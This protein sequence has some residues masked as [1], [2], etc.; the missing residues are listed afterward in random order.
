LKITRVYRDSI[1]VCTACRWEGPEYKLKIGGEGLTHYYLC[2]VCNSAE[3]LWED[4]DD[5]RSKA[6]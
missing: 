6:V 3:V 2:P 4:D 1:Y 5:L